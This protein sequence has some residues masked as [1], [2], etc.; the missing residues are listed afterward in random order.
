MDQ[1]NKNHGNHATCTLV[2][3]LAGVA[4]GA[5]VTALTT[6]KT[7]AERRGDLES[8]ARRLRL[9][10]ESLTNEANEAWTAVKKHV[11]TTGE[12]FKHNCG[13]ECGDD[14]RFDDFE[15]NSKEK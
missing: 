6:K 1:C 11:S 13:S 3:L 5:V 4:I 10:A 2:A 12:H 9:R 7:G 15:P 8:L 14:C